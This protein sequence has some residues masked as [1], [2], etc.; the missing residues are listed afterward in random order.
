MSASR[1]SGEPPA[2]TLSV[3]WQAFSARPDQPTDSSRPRGPSNGAEAPGVDALVAAVR[4][5]QPRATTLTDA[6][7]LF[8]WQRAGEGADLACT[9]AEVES[10]WRL[11]DP[12]PLVVDAARHVI[13]DAWVD[14]VAAE[15]AVPAVDPLSGLH[16]VGYLTGR[17]HELDRID[18]HE[19]SPLVLLVVRWPPPASPWL[20]IAQVLR[21]ATALRDHVR[22]EATLAH[23][24]ATT[25]LALLPDDAR[26][27][28]E[29]GALLRALGGS[30]VR[31][32]DGS[33]GPDTRV[34]LI[35][36]PDDRRQL[37]ELLGRLQDESRTPTK[38][39]PPTR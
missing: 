28:L 21:V 6:L 11:A 32:E 2:T 4:D 23:V 17:I 37:T 16:T 15:R 24:G 27:R 20:R 14:A 7:V 36:V 31:P 35:P 3:S 10:L 38:D 18:R 1:H 33:G 9:L 34:D 22:P 25:A 30:A 19:P 39:H 5:P 29:R 26:S 8:A 12:E 13:V